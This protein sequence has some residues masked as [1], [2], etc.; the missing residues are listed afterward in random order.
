[1][2]FILMAESEGG[3]KMAD[4]ELPLKVWQKALVNCIILALITGISTMQASPDITIR[5]AATAAILTFLV[6][7]KSLLGARGGTIGLMTLV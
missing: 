5:A 6:Q 7:L 3:E 2:I 1:M 4:E